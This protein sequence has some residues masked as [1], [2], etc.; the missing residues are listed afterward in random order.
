MN[1]YFID[2]AGDYTSIGKFAVIPQ[3]N[4]KT[5][6]I[7]FDSVNQEVVLVGEGILRAAMIKKVIFTENDAVKFI[8]SPKKETG[9]PS[10]HVIY[11]KLQID[12]NVTFYH[13]LLNVNWNVLNYDG[14]CDSHGLIGMFSKS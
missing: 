5:N 6:A 14:L 2:T 8:H 4:N 1:A 3:R 11:V 13:N 10:I 9:Y 7:V 12:F